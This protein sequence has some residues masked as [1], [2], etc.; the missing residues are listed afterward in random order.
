MYTKFQGQ[1]I[2]KKKDIQNLPTCVAMK[3]IHC[4]QL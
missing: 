3:K 1:K 4:Y 2:Y